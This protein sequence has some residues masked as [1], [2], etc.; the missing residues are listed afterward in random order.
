MGMDA[1]KPPTQCKQALPVTVP[2][3][4]AGKALV[5]ERLSDGT[6]NGTGAVGYMLTYLD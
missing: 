4:P 3:L 5:E 2:Q 6:E 1:E